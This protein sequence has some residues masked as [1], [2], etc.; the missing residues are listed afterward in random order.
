[1]VQ[2]QHLDRAFAALS[3][4]TRRAILERL[5]E[6]EASISELAAPFTISLTGMKKHVQVLEDAGLVTTHKVGRER[7]CRLAPTQL[8]DAAAWLDAHRQ[9]VEARFDRFAELLKKE[10]EAQP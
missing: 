9:M 2:Y 5:G 7:R 6:G 3:D 1:M 8:E 10:Q 4:P